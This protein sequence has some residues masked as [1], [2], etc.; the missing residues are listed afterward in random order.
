[1]RRVLVLSLILG[2]VAPWAAAET[3]DEVVAAHLEAR[4]GRDRI[5]AVSSVRMSGRM[6]IGEGVEAPFVWEWKR[7]GKFRSEFT[8]QGMKG[9]QAS[10]GEAGWAVAPFT[11]NHDAQ[12]LP[13]EQTRIMKLQADFDGVLMDWQDK[14]HRVKLAGTEEVDGADAI[15]LVVELAGGGTVEVFLDSE[16]FLMVKTVTRHDIGETELEAESTY[17]SYKEVGGLLFAF[18]LENRVKGQ[19][20]SPSILFDAIELDVELDDARFAMP[21]TEQPAEPGKA[22][23]DG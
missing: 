19:P 17:G 3:L 11:G 15:K 2:S 1:M 4:G 13:E 6:L 10:D 16:Y 8:V 14:G 5:Q 23:D 18:S 12:K 9:I 21:V 20:V 22:S 7:P